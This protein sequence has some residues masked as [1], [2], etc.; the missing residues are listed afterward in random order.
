[1]AELIAS[2]PLADLALADLDFGIERT[3]ISTQKYR[4]GIEPL[5]S[6]WL[7][8]ATAAKRFARDDVALKALAGAE[9]LQQKG[10]FPNCRI[11]RLRAGIRLKRDQIAEALRDLTFAIENNPDCKNLYEVRG[12]VN[13][14]A[15]D[16]RAA[17]E[18]Y[19]KI[20]EFESPNLA[21]NTYWKRGKAYDQL[22]E[23]EK[24]S[25]DFT[26]AIGTSTLCEQDYQI[27]ARAFRLA[28]NE[29][30]ARADEEMAAR[31][32]QEQKKYRGS[33]FC[34]HHHTQ[35]PAWAH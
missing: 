23:V 26:R 21:S 27:R 35:F 12:D 8:K 19:S 5:Q 11:Y 25:S 34:S 30:A 4:W 33:D 7:A 15:G 10:S 13:Q 22:G 28:G 20:I 1:V 31:T 6:A 18:D 32:V 24:A 9:Q 14:A 16:L 2:T 29:E 3:K 17:V